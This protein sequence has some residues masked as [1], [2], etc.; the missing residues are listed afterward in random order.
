M[1]TTKTLNARVEKIDPSIESANP[2]N[3]NLSILFKQDGLIFSIHRNDIDKYIVL[4]EYAAAPNAGSFPALFEFYNQLQG[5]FLNLNLAYCG[6]TFTL[7]PAPLFSKNEVLSYAQSQ[8]EIG[9]DEILR[10]D[11]LPTYQVI[12][13][14]TVP[15]SVAD[16]ITANFGQHTLRHSTFFTIS[17]F[18]DAYKNKPGEHFHANFWQQSLEVLAVNNARLTLCSRFTYQSDE[19]VAY[20]ILNCFEQLGLNPETVP[21]KVSGEIEKGSKAWAMLEKFIRFVELETRP[22]SQYSHEFKSL[23]AHQYNRIFQIA[24]CA[25]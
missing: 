21:L 4:G 5:S 23:P 24:Q 11:E 12:I 7:L 20:Y 13:V 16:F 22:A 3:C 8:F 17:Y 1:V 10:I 18:L 14:Y 19:D 15:R 25:S 2:E 6:N 9:A